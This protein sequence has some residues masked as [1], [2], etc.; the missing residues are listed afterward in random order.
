LIAS[1]PKIIGDIRM[2]NVKAVGALI[3]QARALNP[4]ANP[5][6]VRQKLIEL[7]DSSR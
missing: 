3:G 5:A 4:N 1:N 2:G 7:L 6:S